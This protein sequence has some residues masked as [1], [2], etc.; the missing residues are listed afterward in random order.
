MINIFQLL[1]ASNT[2]KD[3][4]TVQR[5]TQDMRVLCRGELVKLLVLVASDALSTIDYQLV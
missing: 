4:T 2:A 1:Y 5:I 3:L